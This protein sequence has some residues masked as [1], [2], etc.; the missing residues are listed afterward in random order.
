MRDILWAEL[1][2]ATARAWDLW[3]DDL[4]KLT[5]AVNA[6][7]DVGALEK[8]LRGQIVKVVIRLAMSRDKLDPRILA[9]LAEAGGS[10]AARNRAFDALIASSPDPD[11]K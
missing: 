5:E 8:E 11:E 6:L 7:A 9:F 10:G 1:K 2:K 4:P 3:G